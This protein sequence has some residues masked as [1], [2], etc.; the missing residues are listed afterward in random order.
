MVDKT[1]FDKYWK[2]SE[3][4]VEKNTENNFV[5]F[6]CAKFWELNAEKNSEKQKFEKLYVEKQ[7]RITL[8]KNPNWTQIKK[9]SSS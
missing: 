4:D 7:K 2:G 6:R 1:Q 5:E 3:L 9:F 8:W